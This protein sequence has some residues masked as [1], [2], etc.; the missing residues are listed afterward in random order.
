[1]QHFPSKDFK[2]LYKYAL[3]KPH[4]Q[5]EVGD[6]L[7]FLRERQPWHRS[8]SRAPECLRFFTGCRSP[9]D[10]LHVKGHLSCLNSLFPPSLNHRKFRNIMNAVKNLF[11]AL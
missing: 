1:M 3:I 9:C 7:P 5:L 11:E 8:L 6:F 2:V 4:K 10:V